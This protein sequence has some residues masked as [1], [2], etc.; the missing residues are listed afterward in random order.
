VK[1]LVTG[2]FG[3]VGMVTL[4][5][6]LSRGHEVT[7]FARRAAHNERAAR[8][9][10]RSLPPEVD[11]GLL[12]VHWGDVRDSADLEAAVKD[13]DAVIHLAAMLPPRCDTHPA[14]C[15][16]VNVGGTKN[17]VDA[18]RVEAARR[19]AGA[20]ERT[21][22]S[23][24]G[25]V[26]M[27][28]REAARAGGAPA[29]VY[30]SSV[31]VMGSTQSKEPPVRAD[32]PPRPSDVHSRTKVAAE[33]LVRGSALPW[34]ILR[35]SGVMPTSGFYQLSLARLMFD[36]S[37]AARCEIVVDVDAAYALVQ[38]AESL[39]DGGRI[40]GKTVFIAGGKDK[41]CQMSTRDMI[42]HSLAPLGLKSPRHHL[43]RADVGSYYLDWYDTAE[44]QKI[45]GYQRHSV[46]DWQHLS[47]RRFR[48]LRWVL[49]PVRGL[50]RL[51]IES[52]APR[53]RPP[54]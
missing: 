21:D 26:E 31:S 15:E 2:G 47:F 4:R 43:F 29:L 17:L 12:R 8:R 6:A 1:V 25:A 24:G 53:E 39:C 35:L 27:G 54:A 45:L 28:A 51:V 5:E 44:G 49:W 37:L 46:A 32:Y 36:M 22:G 18:L 16:A 23:A 14:L 52:T 48:L 40:A 30:V 10:R 19:G 20:A 41:G 9:L 33:A 34:A 42:G 38:A 3:T 50:A 11:N 7:V 13:H